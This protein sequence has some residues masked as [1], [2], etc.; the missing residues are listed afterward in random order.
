MNLC[1]VACGRLDAF[2]EINFGGCWDVAAAA[3]VLQ[4]AGGR[5]LDPCGKEFSVMSRRVLGT[6][7]HLGPAMAAVLNTCR[8]SRAEPL[9]PAVW[10]D[11]Y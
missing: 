2:W 10:I 5:V 1:G 11:E 4:E 3:L 6:N 8:S 9:P 7:A